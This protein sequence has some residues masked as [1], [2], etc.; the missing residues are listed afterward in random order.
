MATKFIDR[1]KEMVLLE[2]QYALPQASFV[3]IYGRRR[4]GKTRL[5]AEFL[6]KHETDSL[7][8]LVTEESEN[9]NLAVFRKLCGKYLGNDLLAVST[10]SWEDS[11]R[12]FAQYHP[13]RKKILVI[14]EF[15]Y[16][17][18]CNPA[19]P[20]IVQKIWDLVFSEANIMLV[21][22]GSLVS[23][24]KTQTLA[25]SSPL[26]GRRTA[27]LKLKQ[28]PFAHYGDFFTSL[29]GRDLVDRYAI[30][31]GVPRYIEAFQGQGDLFCLIRQNILNPGSFLY[32]EP[33][34]LLQKEVKQIGSYF[35]LLRTIAFGNHKLN[36]I[37]T[38]LSVKA[39]DLTSYLKILSDLD[40]VERE[41]PVFESNPEK[42]KSGL[43]RITDNY[44]AFWFKFVYPW[45]NYLER[46]EDQVVFDNLKRNFVQ[47]HAAFVYE[48][49]C[50]ERMWSLSAA[51]SWKFPVEKVGRYWGRVTDETDI[52]ALS[53]GTRNM[54]VGECKYS[55]SPKDDDVLFALE[56]RGRALSSW[57]GVPDV[58]YVLF[59]MGGFTDNLRSLASCRSDVLLVEDC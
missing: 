6:K 4:T 18:V 29:K 51:G 24:M 32:E 57:F 44:I 25:Y 52:V 48:D 30:T 10:A 49:V 12:L 17:G 58:Q 7:Y 55:L 1:D 31:G 43:Y 11:C 5:I 47:R 36:D 13:E 50:R 45:Q 54:V 34:F 28:I 39:T 21:L 9:Q 22:S 41:V 33:Y 14:D 35:S 16:L 42:S 27:Q 56:R 46:G 37:A 38:V 2:K 19:F 20:S 59:S 23:L 26:Y 15:Q 8:F 40:L 3:V 53:E